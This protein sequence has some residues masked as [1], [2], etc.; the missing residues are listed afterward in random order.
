M[1]ALGRAVRED[2]THIHR[3]GVTVDDTRTPAAAGFMRQWALDKFQHIINQLLFQRQA[4]WA[5]ALARGASRTKSSARAS[6]S[7][8]T[9]S[10][11][12]AHGALPARHAHEAGQERL[13][14][15]DGASRTSRRRSR[16]RSRGWDKSGISLS[17]HRGHAARQRVKEIRTMRDELRAN[18]AANKLQCVFL[19]AR[20]T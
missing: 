5:C 7:R 15:L 12:E 18:E 8:S 20:Q 16:R 10:G 11:P 2:V 17:A 6:L 13:G 19:R 14:A 1:D 3:L 4:G 9:A